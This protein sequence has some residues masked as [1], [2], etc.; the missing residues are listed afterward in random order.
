MAGAI[1]K[2]SGSLE[3]LWRKQRQTKAECKL[4]KAELARGG[5]KSSSCNTSKFCGPKVLVYWYSRANTLTISLKKTGI[6]PP[7]YKIIHK[8]LGW[9]VLTYMRS[10]GEEVSGV[11]RRMAER[12]S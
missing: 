10:R 9:T 11:V 4:C 3:I 1:P 6:K 5:T 7:Y 2:T 12:K 8:L